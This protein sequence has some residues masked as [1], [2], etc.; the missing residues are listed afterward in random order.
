MTAGT[1]PEHLDVIVIGSGISGIGA[2]Y[3]LQRDH[4]K[5]RY[6]ILEARAD[7]G[8]TWDLFRYPGIRSDSDLHTFGYEFKPWRNEKAIA[9]APAI[10]SYLRET[11][12]EHGIDRNV[13]FH[14]KV[15][16]A[17]WSSEQA[18]WR[19]EVERT[20]SGER[21]AFTC[22]WLFCASGFY[23]YDEGFTPQF[24]GR[25]RFQ[26]QIVHPQ[27]WPESLDHRGRRVLV[28]GSG[29]TAV[30]L[31][32]ALA[33]TA[34][35]VT[36]VQRTPS[37]ILPLPSKDAVANSLRR[38]LGEERGYALTRRK[39]I[40]QQ[41]ALWRFCQ[42]YPKLARRL[43]RSVNARQLPPG[44]PVD[45]HFNPPYDPW[46][47]RLCVVPDGDLFQ[48]LRDGTASIV[49][50]RITTFTE[51]GIQLA[52]G[53]VLE[54]D[55][56]VTATGLNVLAFGGVELSVDGARVN[57][58]DTVAYKGMMLSG[59]PNFAYAI[60]Y[61]NSSWTLKVGLLCEH[62]CRLLS[63]MDARGYESCRPETTGPL[64][65]RPMLDLAAGY[66]RR[67]LTELPRQGNRSPWQV[68]MDYHRDR[69]LLRYGTVED[70]NL[71]FASRAD[72][73]TD[74]E[75]PTAPGEAAALGTPA[76]ISDQSGD[77][78]CLLPNGMRICYRSEGPLDGPPLLL[79]AGLSLDLTSWPQVLMDGFIDRGFRV[80]RFDNRD[81]GRSSRIAVPPPGRLRQLGAR[82]RPDAYDLGDMTAD[83]L[84]LL[85]HLELPRVHVLGM[86]MGGMIAQTLAARHPDRVASLTSIFSTTGRRSVGQPAPST[87]VRMARPLSRTQEQ[88]VTRHL[89]MLRHIG[90]DRFP[91]DEAS[92]RAW[93]STVWDRAGAVGRHA[94]VAR[95][96][97]AIQASGDRTAELRSIT[98]PTLV[99]HGDT[100][101][102]VHPSGGKATAAAILGAR[103]V[104]IAGMAHH[105]SP[106]LLE[107]LLELVTD[108]ANQVDRLPAAETHTVQ[109]H[110]AESHPAEAR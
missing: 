14:H 37:Y 104:E 88:S 87:L 9:G 80:I 47:Q 94:G 70:P 32:P 79:I 16:R 50:D 99:I 2:A 26:G 107:R 96:I 100:D 65:T 29:A 40:A 75:K 101:R 42:K 102:M 63:H 83:T 52:S 46:D 30:T 19:V 74:A 1:E 98:A 56:I 15:L 85:D 28:I 17:S 67:A 61:T 36:M 38:I 76:P 25:E 33:T 59:V 7:S 48:A 92:E 97:S 24:E 10:L 12:A 78:F 54:A 60:G 90:S 103:H 81:A 89:A 86:S 69:K 55:I 45:E 84:G 109:S 44:Y 66:I 108:H 58:P 62:F 95:Q 41:R 18:Q 106:G 39:N 77:Q 71:R 93:A 53:R 51:T 73:R 5:R 91:F 43:I 3:Y 105:L 35:H 64:D 82:P 4:P 110:S 23:R 68:P 20:D 31:V 13:R 22:R 49:T 6:A 11:A 34:A 57:L 8:G 27:F 21:T 72:S